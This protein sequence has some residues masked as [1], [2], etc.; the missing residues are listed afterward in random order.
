MNTRLGLLQWTEGTAG[1]ELVANARRLEDLGYHELWL[2]EICGREPLS[3]AGYLLGQTTRINVS[4]GI[5]NVYAR[6]ADCAAQT[7]NG[8]AEL[9]GGRFRLGLGVSHPV[10]VEPRGHQWVPPV[11]KMR[12][13]LGRLRAAPIDSPRAAVPAPVIVA[14]HGKGLV[15]VARE[16]GDGS[17]LFLQ[18]VE[19]VRM[20][21]EL[22]G[23][24][25]ELHVAVRCVLDADAARARDLARRA[26]AF[27]ISLPAYH[28][29]W[30]ELGFVETDWAD[31]GSDRLIDA[32]CT[33]GDADMLRVKL[34]H[35]V[36]AGA[37]HIVLY[38]C[39]PSE[40]YRPDSAMST[41]WNWPLLEALAPG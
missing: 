32:I 10:L 31:G 27:Y 35:Y 16:L 6:D 29:R 23:P 37:S 22:L 1:H 19:A 39:N 15:R 24:D 8:L 2:P 9:S 4:S 28:A 13:Y 18:P 33:W 34:A 14:G 36:E 17:F 25:K 26:C 3:T 41:H 38:P 40:D 11:R 7:A 5:A 30:G 12:D 20:A 21:R